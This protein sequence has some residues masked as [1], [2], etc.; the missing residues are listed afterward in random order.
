MFQ[1]KDI[2]KYTRMAASRNEKS[3]IVSRIHRR[4]IWD[5]KVRRGPEINS[6]LKW[7]WPRLS[8]E[9]SSNNMGST[10]RAGKQ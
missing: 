9:D 10:E 7:W 2:H 3:I 8:S 4:G 5:V 1:H 6:D